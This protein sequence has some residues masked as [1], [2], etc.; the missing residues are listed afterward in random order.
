[1]TCALQK[2]PVRR[3][4]TGGE[5]AQALRSILEQIAA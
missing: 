4:R 1:V 3:Y 2:D 5:F